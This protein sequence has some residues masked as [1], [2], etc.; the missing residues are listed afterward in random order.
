MKHYELLEP[1]QIATMKEFTK[2]YQDSLK[3]KEIAED[4]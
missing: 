3:N 1:T 2:R 4:E